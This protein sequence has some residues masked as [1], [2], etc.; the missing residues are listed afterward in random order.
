MDSIFLSCPHCQR[1]IRQFTKDLDRIVARV[2]PECGER[3][4]VKENQSIAAY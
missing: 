2:C 3:V 4:N 1:R